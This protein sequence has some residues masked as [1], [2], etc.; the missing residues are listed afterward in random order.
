M[1]VKELIEKIDKEHSGLDFIQISYGNNS[2][3]F[4][5][6]V[7]EGKNIEM[8]EKYLDKEVK[9]IKF[10]TFEEYDEDWDRNSYVSYVGKYVTIEVE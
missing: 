2:G 8:L 5:I 3:S 4:N 7:F 9:S 10:N 6:D 1:L